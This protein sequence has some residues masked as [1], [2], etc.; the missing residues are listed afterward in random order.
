MN[1]LGKYGVPQ[2]I[3][4][5]DDPQIKYPTEVKA[6]AHIYNPSDAQFVPAPIGPLRIWCC[7][8]RSLQPAESF[9]RHAGRPT[10][11]QQFCKPCQKIHR[12]AK[13]LR[14]I[15]EQHWYR[16]PLSNVSHVLSREAKV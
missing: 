15:P 5:H 1:H 8:C 4:I 3:H 6:A 7:K 16:D 13:N 10:G 14:Q 2:M 9:H 11:Y 12:K